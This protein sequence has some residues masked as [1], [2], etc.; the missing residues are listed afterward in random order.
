MKTR[1][2]LLSVL[3]PIFLLSF[4]SIGNSRG[5]FLD[6]EKQVYDVIIGDWAMETE[7]QGDLIPALMTLSVKDGKLA[8]V[9]VSM[10]Q[11]MEMIDLEFDGKNLGFKRAM[12][13]GGQTIDFEGIVEGDEISG[14]YLSP[15]GGEYKCT[16]QRKGSDL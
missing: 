15:M 12:G 1:K 11:E 3:M 13:E 16:G 2:V 10:D 9:W 8:G 5:S 14:N 6:Q 7:F 4:P